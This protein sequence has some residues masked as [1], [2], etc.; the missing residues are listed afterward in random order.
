MSKAPFPI[1][2]FLTGLALAYSNRALIGDRVLP[3]VPVGKQEFKWWKYDKADRFTIP[4]T[5]VGRTSRV[6]EV[7]FGATEETSSTRDYG[8]EDPIPQSDIDNAPANY[9]P[10]S[11]ATEA[12]TDLIL[13][14]REVRVASLVFDPATYGAQHE[15]LANADKFDAPNSDPIELIGDKLDSTLMRAN[16][17]VFGRDAYRTLSRNTSI[18]KASNRNDGDKGIARRQDIADLFEIPV[19]NILVGEG[20][21]NTAKKG[22]TPSFVRVWGDSIAM[23]HLNPVANTRSGVTFGYSAQWGTRVSGSA[24]D[25]DIGLRGGERVRVGE[26]LK[27]LIVAPDCGY[28]LS[29][30]NGY[31]P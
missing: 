17:L 9:N 23:L 26:S 31:T 15:A 19:E 2:P 25:R 29:D 28:L 24:Y 22:Q 3:R 20:F 4:K 13:L 12:L 18:V 5:L 1:D 7:E 14:D 11:Y 21:V 30:V 6:N 27:E 16:T 10:K 8:L